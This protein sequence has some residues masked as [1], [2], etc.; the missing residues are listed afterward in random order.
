PSSFISLAEETD[1]VIAIDRFVLREACRRAAEWEDLSGAP[2]R[3]S[4]NLSP[5]WLRQPNALAELQ[6]IVRES[7]LPWSRLQIEITERL[8]MAE[9]EISTA[10]LAALRQ[11]GVHVAVDDFGTGH[12]ALGYLQRFPI[13]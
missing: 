9:D 8:A 13:D 6:V 1:L 2:V 4:V 3:I 10:V 11:L 7:E 12:S 5:R